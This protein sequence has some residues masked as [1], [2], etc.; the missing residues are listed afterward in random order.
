MMKKTVYS[1]L[2]C[3][4]PC[5]AAISRTPIRQWFTSM[6]DSVMPLLTMNNRLDFIDFLDCHMEA[7]VTNRFDGKS[8]MDTLTEDY[9]RI[10][11]TRTCEVS[12]KLLPVNDTTDVLCMVTTMQAAVP[13]SRIAFYDAHWQPLSVNDFM[14]EPSLDDFRTADSSDSARVAWSKVLMPSRT[15]HASATDT[16]LVCRLSALDHL[17]DADREALAP[18]LRTD[19]LVLRWHDGRYQQ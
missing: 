10:R 14:D 5:V 16:R 7:V 13:D 2:L 3:V 4:L 18:Y 11:Y 12:M 17:A 8:R 1:L 6:P 15:Y 9:L 19:T